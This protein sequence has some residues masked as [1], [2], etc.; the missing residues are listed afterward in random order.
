MTSAAGLKLTTDSF[1]AKW[2]RHSVHA[3]GIYLL[4]AIIVII[5]I[6]FI[7]RALSKINVTQCFIK[8]EK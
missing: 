4:G 8:A 2:I 6:I 5:I 1:T 3:K 7:Y